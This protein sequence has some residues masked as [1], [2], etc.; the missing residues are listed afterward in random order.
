MYISALSAGSGA[1]DHARQIAEG[2]DDGRDVVEGHL[3]LPGRGADL[4]VGGYLLGLCLGDPRADNG[5]VSPASRLARYWLVFALYR[6]SARGPR[7]PGRGL[8]GPG[9]GPLLGEL[10]ERG[11]E[12]GR[13]EQFR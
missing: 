2:G 10:A 5:G 6:R 8:R 1:V 3:A 7:P 13:A 11:L 12:A 9:A 4:G